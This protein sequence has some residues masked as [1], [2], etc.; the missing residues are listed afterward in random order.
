MKKKTLLQILIPLV[1]VALIGG[2]WLIKNNE[3]QAAQAH[4]AALTA[5]NPAF[6]LIETSVDLEGYLSHN[7]PVIMDFG[8]EDC[9]P[10]QVMKPAL[11]KAHE[12]NI[13][14][15][16]IKFFDVWEHPETAGDYPIMVI[17]TQVLFNA[18]GTP[19][20]PSEKVEQAGISFDFYNLQGTQEHALTV[21]V[22]IL[23]DAAFELILAD[24]GV[25][26]ERDT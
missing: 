6:R 10:C 14:R 7:L 4:Q 20:K 18:D 23:D 1:I 25:A 2:L 15:A 9:P 3:R 12:Q 13:G 22:G 19:Y 11:E 21:H 5:D 17:P 24:M 8:A 16:V 26:D